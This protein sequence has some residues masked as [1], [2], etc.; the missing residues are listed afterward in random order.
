MPKEWAADWGRCLSDFA[1]LRPAD[2]DE[3]GMDVQVLSFTS[4]GLEA[5]RTAPYA[6]ADLARIAHGNAERVRRL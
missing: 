1:E 3:H 2:M 6:P 5:V 4:T